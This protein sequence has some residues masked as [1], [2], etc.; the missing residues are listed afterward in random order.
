MGALTAMLDK[1]HGM[2]DE[3]WWFHVYVILSRA[4]HIGHL[5]LYGLPPKSLFEKGP[6]AW[7]RSRLRD[8]DLRT[9][10]TEKWAERLLLKLGNFEVYERGSP[11][12]ADAGRGVSQELCIA[13]KVQHRNGKRDLEHIMSEP[14]TSDASAERGIA[15]VPPCTAGDVLCTRKKQCRSHASEKALGSPTAVCTPNTNFASPSLPSQN[16]S[17]HIVRM[18]VDVECTS[19]VSASERLDEGQ[20]SVGTKRRWL[21]QRLRISNH[22]YTTET[23][24]S[25]PTS[26]E[27]KL[28]RL[29]RQYDLWQL[30]FGSPGITG[31]KKLFYTSTQGSIA[32]IRNGGNSCF[33][34]AV[35]QLFLRVEPLYRLFQKHQSVCK[36]SRSDCT[37]FA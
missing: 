21:R 17:K 34:I 16:A 31:G 11:T 25:Q 7:L 36:L 27:F 4:R 19:G 1:N 15:G 10:E 29:R 6:P 2:D 5:L 8:F 3:Q 9:R 14:E 28:F 35:L 13:D 23:A 24:K 12:A 20:R 18:E 33:L 22:V 37:V 30:V 26:G 32:G